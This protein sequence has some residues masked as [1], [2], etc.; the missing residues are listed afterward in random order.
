MQVIATQREHSSQYRLGKTPHQSIII[1]IIQIRRHLFS[2]VPI[3]DPGVF[4]YPR[5]PVLGPLSGCPS[6]TR[7]IKYDENIVTHKMTGCHRGER[8]SMIMRSIYPIRTHITI[9]HFPSCSRTFPPP[10][11][12]VRTTQAA[13][14][15]AMRFWATCRLFRPV[16][17]ETAVL[18]LSLLRGTSSSLTPKITSMWQGWPW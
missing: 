7:V 16:N 9:S 18:S 10:V 11:N 6:G 4:K 15:A 5:S 13:R 3:S 14:T 1:R 12:Q 17:F 8:T 2:L